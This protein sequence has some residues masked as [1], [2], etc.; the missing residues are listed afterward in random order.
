M[1]LR[2]PIGSFIGLVAAGLGVALVPRLM[3]D[4]ALQ[5]VEFLELD[6]L[7]DKIELLMVGRR[8]D[9]SPAVRNFVAMAAEAAGREPEAR[10]S[11]VV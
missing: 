3:R 9:R 10:P 6:D 8:Q 7:A 2:S 5:N 11:A 1:A 4:L